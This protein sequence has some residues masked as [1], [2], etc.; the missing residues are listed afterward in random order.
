MIFPFTLLFIVLLTLVPVGYYEW[1]ARTGGSHRGVYAPKPRWTQT[2][3]GDGSGVMLA[4][5]LQG[6]VI[7]TGSVM[8]PDSVS[9]TATATLTMTPS[10]G[11]LTLP[12]LCGEPPP[13]LT[14]AMLEEIYAGVEARNREV[15]EAEI[16]RLI[17]RHERIYHPLA[18]Q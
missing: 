15:R 7:W 13:P 17:Q 9:D 8:F 16:E 10:E 6:S 5:V 3:E 12:L 18:T 4:D 1:D 2:Y 14:D 11:L